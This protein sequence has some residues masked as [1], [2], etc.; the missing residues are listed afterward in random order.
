MVKKRLV[1]IL[2]PEIWK[3]NH[4][5]SRQMTVI[6]TKNICNLEKHP[7]FERSGFHMVGTTDIAKFITRPFDNQTI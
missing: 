2:N 7:D 4:L 3:P 1:L 5:I 6:S